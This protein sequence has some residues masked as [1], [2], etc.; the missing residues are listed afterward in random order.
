MDRREK[1]LTLLI[2]GTLALLGFGVLFHMAMWL[3]R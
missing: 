2:T 1:L 3:S